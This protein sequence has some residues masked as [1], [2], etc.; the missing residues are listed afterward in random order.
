M[1]LVLGIFFLIVIT[2]SVSSE[3]IIVNR[4]NHIL[5]S[6]YK[7]HKGPPIEILAKASNKTFDIDEE[8][9]WMTQPLNHFDPHDQRTF[10]MRYMQNKEYLIDSGPIFIFVGGEWDIN[11][12]MFNYLLYFGHLHDMA[13]ELNGALFYTEH[14]YYGET[15]PT[16]NLSMENLRYLNTDQALADLAHFIV[17]IKASDPMLENS[18]VIIAGCSYSA[19]MVTWFAQKYPHLVSGTWALS[20][21]LKT[22]VDYPE[23]FDEVESSIRKTGGDE[24]ANRIKL[25]FQQLQRWVDEKNSGLIEEGMLLCNPINFDDKYEVEA[26]FLALATNWAAIVQF[27]TEEFQIIQYECSILLESDTGND[28]WNYANW[29]WHFYF[30]QNRFDVCLDH[31]IIADLSN[32]KNIGYEDNFDRTWTYQ[33]CSALGW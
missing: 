9:S 28:V 2:I 25:A 4:H 20:A 7:L 1:K 32:I 30:E 22:Q 19:T 16:E 33:T 31:T 13:M 12:E 29:Y 17:Q 10:Q 11:E 21:P 14:R 27:H 15:R 8:I 6:K 3:K 18:K 5:N 24:C 23:F 26:L